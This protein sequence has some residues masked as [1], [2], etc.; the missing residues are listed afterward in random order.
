MNEAAESGPKL[1]VWSKLFLGLLML[2]PIVGG[3]AQVWLAVTAAPG[4]LHSRLGMGIGG[5]VVALWVPVAVSA[6]LIWRKIKYGRFKQT[7]EERAA[8][9]AKNRLQ[10]P[11]PLALRIG[12]PVTFA[13]LAIVTT[14]KGLHAH[15]QDGMGWYL[16]A[17][18]WVNAVIWTCAAFLKKPAGDPAAPIALNLGQD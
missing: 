8:I 3:A 17:M 18:Y 1:G 16:P 12:L 11:Q 13:V 6:S 7:E 10:Q 14:D 9:R 5:G 15:A 4:E 2:F